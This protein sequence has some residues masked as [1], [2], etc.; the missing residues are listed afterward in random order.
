[1]P[2]VRFQWSQNG[3]I[4]SSKITIFY[5]KFLTHFSINFSHFQ[6][7]NLCPPKS[8][9]L[10]MSQLS[11]PTSPPPDPSKNTYFYLIFQSFFSH[12][13]RFAPSTY[14]FSP[15]TT[16]IFDQFRHFFTKNQPPDPKYLPLLQNSTIIDVFPLVTNSVCFKS[17]P[18][19]AIFVN[20]EFSR[21]LIFIKTQL[22]FVNLIAEI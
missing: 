4:F 21:P 14:R 22:S 11:S 2:S 1:M 13:Q 3:S 9:T 8:P 12:F 7:S 16:F 15:K 19:L 17:C 5:T 6:M 18:F 20:L 10:S